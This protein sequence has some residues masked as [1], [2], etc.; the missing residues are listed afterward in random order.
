VKELLQLVNAA[1]A[2]DKITLP[3]AEAF[4]EQAKNAEDAAR[5]WTESVPEPILAMF[6]ELLGR[7]SAQFP[8]DDASTSG[9]LIH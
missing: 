2:E 9:P 6:S 5:R 3:E 1:L 8:E 7:D 4:R